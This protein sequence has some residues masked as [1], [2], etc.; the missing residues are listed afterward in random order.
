[1]INFLIQKRK[2]STMS[3]VVKLQWGGGMFRQE[4][5][6]DFETQS[7]EWNQV[8]APSFGDY[9]SE[10]IGR[11]TPTVIGAA[12]VFTQAAFY[13]KLRDQKLKAKVRPYEETTLSVRPIQGIPGEVTSKMMNVI[14]QNRSTYAGSDPT[15][16][17][18]SKNIAGAQRQKAYDDY[19]MKEAEA[20]MAD[21][22]RFDTQTRENEARVADIR[23]KN[24]DRKQQEDEYRQAAQLDFLKEKQQLAGT[25]FDQVQQSIYNE[26][27]Y[28]AK[29]TQVQRQQ[30]M[31]QLNWQV[32]LKT[33]QLAKETP[34]TPGHTNLQNE[35]NGLYEQINTLIETPPPTTGQIRGGL[36][37]GNIQNTS[38]VPRTYTNPITGESS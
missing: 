30:Q 37:S 13:K 10:G 20:I 17:L 28:N 23:S 4:N 18:I 14:E 16:D 15:M 36:F 27:L 33:Q 38:L 12:N 26:N 35:I 5:P 7:D 6:V 2:E 34:G 25:T 32:G 3:K 21:R 11:A 9:V 24:L 1:M 8:D 19:S 31:Q 29:A 22:G